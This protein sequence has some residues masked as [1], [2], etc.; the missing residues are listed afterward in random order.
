M[1]PRWRNETSGSFVNDG[2]RV[3][4]RKNCPRGD[5]MAS[6]YTPASVTGFLPPLECGVFSNA[7]TAASFG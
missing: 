2:V 7:R 3:R 6:R 5:G 4:S 1:D